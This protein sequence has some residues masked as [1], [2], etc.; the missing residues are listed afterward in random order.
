MYSNGEGMP[1]HYVEA[2]KWYN[3]AAASAPGPKNRDMAVK[4]RDKVSP[5]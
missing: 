4:N 1:Q 3:L 2:Q 5:S